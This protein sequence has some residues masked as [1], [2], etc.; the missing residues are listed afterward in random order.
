MF[1]PKKIE[2]PNLLEESI[3]SAFN[4]LEEHD[5]GTEKYADIIDKIERLIALRPKKKELTVSG[6]ALVG[7]ITNILGIG[8]VLNYEKLGVVTSKAF[9]LLVKSKM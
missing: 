2:E 6:D 3:A 9:G 1:T 7:A 5:A 8:L 4:Q